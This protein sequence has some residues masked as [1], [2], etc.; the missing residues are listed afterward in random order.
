RFVTGSAPK[1]R[2]RIATPTGT[3]GVR[4]AAFDFFVGGGITS[5]LLYHGAVLFCN[6][7]GD[8]EMLAEACD[9]G[10]FDS[11]EAQ[12]IGHTGLVGGEDRGVLTAMFRYA[13][14]QAPLLREF[15]V[16]EAERCLKRRAGGGAPESLV[17]SGPGG[18]QPRGRTTPND[19]G[20]VD[21]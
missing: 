9:L 16:A 14:S 2:Y 13:L 8:C 19:P 18:G 21:G 15:R 17:D 1:D 12:R 7:A 11:S 6:N 20:F 5:V 4:G 10:Q 3:I